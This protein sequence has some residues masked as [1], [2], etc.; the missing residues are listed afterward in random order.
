MPYRTTKSLAA[1][2]S[3][4]GAKLHFSLPTKQRGTFFLAV[5]PALF[6]VL[7]AMY[8]T[9][10]NSCRSSDRFSRNPQPK[11]AVMPC[12]S[13]L[14]AAVFA[15]SLP[16]FASVLVGE[17]APKQSKKHPQCRQAA[18]VDSQTADTLLLRATWLILKKRLDSALYQVL[19]G[20]GIKTGIQ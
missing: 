13:C 9:C 8:M 19:R 3:L 6:Y 18:N 16:A 20:L 4:L 12:S 10:K 7:A 1:M 5:F 14:S 2:L 15:A 11:V 17:D